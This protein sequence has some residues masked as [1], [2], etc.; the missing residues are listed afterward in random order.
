MGFAMFSINDHPTCLVTRVIG[1]NN[2]HWSSSINQDDCPIHSRRLIGANEAIQVFYRSEW[3]IQRSLKNRSNIPLP[4]QIV[5]RQFIKTQLIG[6]QFP[7]FFSIY[8]ISPAWPI[9]VF[10]VVIQSLVDFICS[11]F[12]LTK[13]YRPLYYFVVC[14]QFL[15]GGLHFCAS[16]TT[17]L[18]CLSPPFTGCPRV[19]I[20]GW[21]SFLHTCNNE[22]TKIK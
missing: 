12:N 9:G 19:K 4:V 17:G 21:Y 15:C 2:I 7:L 3:V 5:S 20:T 8:S 6:Y 16:A 18:V 10:P 22:R 13:N 1:P 14:G 11:T